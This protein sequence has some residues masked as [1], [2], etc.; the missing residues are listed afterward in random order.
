MKLMNKI[1][2]L[3]SDKTFH[4]VVKGSLELAGFYLP[5]LFLAAPFNLPLAFFLPPLLA[6]LA[7][8][9][10]KHRFPFWIG[11][12]LT[13]VAVLL[14]QVSSLHR[15]AGSTYYVECAAFE[16]DCLWT[17]E[18][19]VLETDI[20]V[21]PYNA[22]F[23]LLGRLK[24]KLLQTSVGDEAF[25]SLR[26]RASKLDGETRLHSPLEFQIFEY[27]GGDRTL[28]GVQISYS[29][30]QLS[31]T[32]PVST[33][34]QYRSVKD[35]SIILKVEPRV[36]RFGS[37]RQGD[38]FGATQSSNRNF[39][40]FASG[41]PNS[42]DTWDRLVRND[43]WFERLST[44]PADELIGSLRKDQTA[45]WPSERLLLESWDLFLNCRAPVSPES[46]I[47][48][49]HRLDQI[50][51]LRRS[52]PGNDEWATSFV[53]PLLQGASEG[54]SLAVT[55][56]KM[57]EAGYFSPNAVEAIQNAE[58]I[59]L[60]SSLNETDFSVVELA[61]ILGPMDKTMARADLEYSLSDR[62][63][64][65]SF[66]AN[67]R[68]PDCGPNF[69]TGFM[70]EFTSA[71]ANAL[72]SIL[73]RQSECSDIRRESLLDFL[74]QEDVKF[75]IGLLSYLDSISIFEKRSFVIH[76]VRE[77]ERF[78]FN[79]TEHDFAQKYF[80]FISEAFT[81][82]RGIVYTESLMELLDEV[83]LELYRDARLDARKTRVLM[84][85]QDAPPRVLAMM[86]ASSLDKDKRIQNRE[87]ALELVGSI[88]NS[89]SS[90]KSRYPASSGS[91]GTD[92]DRLMDPEVG[93]LNGSDIERLAELFMP[94]WSLDF[95][96]EMVK[97]DFL[98]ECLDDASNTVI[99]LAL[100]GGLELYQEATGFEAASTFVETISG[101]C[102]KVSQIARLFI[103]PSDESFDLALGI[104]NLKQSYPSLADIML[105]NVEELE[106]RS[107][108]NDWNSA[109]KI[110][111]F[112]QLGNAALGLRLVDWDRARA[113]RL[114]YETDDSVSPWTQ[115]EIEG[116]TNAACSLWGDIDD[117][118][119]S[120][121]DESVA[122]KYSG[123]LVALARIEALCDPTAM[124]RVS[125]TLFEHYGREVLSALDNFRVSPLQRQLLQNEIPVGLDAMSYSP[126]TRSQREAAAYF[127]LLAVD[128]FDSPENI[129]LTTSAEATKIPYFEPLFLPS[130]SIL[131]LLLKAG[132]AY[133]AASEALLTH[134]SEDIRSATLRLFLNADTEASELTELLIGENK[135]LDEQE[136]YHFVALVEVLRQTDFTAARELVDVLLR[137]EIGPAAKTTVVDV[138][139]ENGEIVLAA[140]Q[141]LLIPSKDIPLFAIARWTNSFVSEEGEL[142]VP[143]YT[144]Y[145][146]LHHMHRT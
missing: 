82:P 143:S 11:A 145:S 61:Q 49:R 10:W 135:R 38:L 90:L 52:L 93:A 110:S 87:D 48:C 17:Y 57:V 6:L 35:G 123:V 41:D 31:R 65:G 141:I 12:S 28:G 9:T 15:H 98:L 138:L 103:N 70:N 50:Q 133:S 3:P 32:I 86:S 4:G 107:L 124:S 91:V 131:P 5:L 67:L 69:E 89:L 128:L 22:S 44:V 59:V 78:Q 68:S 51:V 55:Y 29:F 34:Y 53:D 62:F 140:S 118:E 79:S 100:A 101:N 1:D 66:S 142:L 134:N 121:I 80:S 106:L 72:T 104:M 14:L 13:V 63:P 122:W 60:D 139:I 115:S 46:V 8:A 108:K 33:G 47:G 102:K 25:G 64:G 111:F 94:D 97:L 96:G 120:L 144:V 37:E 16:Y 75:E 43:L 119:N 58:R 125:S 85:L 24:R 40:F 2:V 136:L 21:W 146:A 26:V 73:A 19:T 39:S 42:R 54:A 84:E 112:E 132:A 88:L 105:P 27:L 18:M 137:T 20:R 7:Y 71:S 126:S 56:G 109:Y 116:A 45:F 99:E 95:G 117:L 92:L 74:L 130:Q 76:L 81:N 30:D 83:Q 36:T 127:G 23:P 113:N 129:D 114:A 77:I